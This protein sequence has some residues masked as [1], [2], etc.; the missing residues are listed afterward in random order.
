M[1]QWLKHPLTIGN[2][3]ITQ[4]R[5]ENIQYLLNMILTTNPIMIQLIKK[6]FISRAHLSP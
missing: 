3:E 5:T 1:L 4:S 2:Y 6:P